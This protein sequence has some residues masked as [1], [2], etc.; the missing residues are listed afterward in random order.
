MVIMAQS[1]LASQL[2]S[3]HHPNYN[4]TGLENSTGS[5]SYFSQVYMTA[6]MRSVASVQIWKFSDHWQINSHI[7]HFA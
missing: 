6:C 3:V 7:A 2:M 5:S 4:I 1:S